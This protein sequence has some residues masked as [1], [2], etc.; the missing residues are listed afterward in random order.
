MMSNQILEFS[1]GLLAVLSFLL[2]LFSILKNPKSLTVKFWFL[3]CLAI[4][5][6]ATGLFFLIGSDTSSEGVYFSKILHAAAAFIPIFFLHFIWSFTHQARSKK[7]IVLISLGYFLALFF[8]A[9]SFTDKIVAGS[10]PKLGFSSWVDAGSWYPLFIVY[11]WAYV[12]LAIYWIYV[13]YSSNDG[14][15]KQKT[16]YL[17]LGSLVLSLGG[18]SNFLPQT[19]GI[20]PYGDFIVWLYPIIVTYGIFVDEIKFKIKF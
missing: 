16:F 15:I 19:L 11:F 3:L 14:I 8:L 10:S 7:N 18:G 20:Y 1:I 6:W 4:G 12:L 9:L 13:A 5:L 17:L 2:G